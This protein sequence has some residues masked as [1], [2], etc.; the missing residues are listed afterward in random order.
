[1]QFSLSWHWIFGKNLLP[2]QLYSILS[3]RQEI[4]VVEQNCPYQ[5]ADGR[6]F[7]CYHLLGF[8]A[9]DELIT[10]ARIF[11]PKVMT[12]DEKLI[13]I[14]R[15]VVKQ[16]YRGLQLG[17]QLMK[18]AEEYAIREFQF[19]HFALHAQAHLQR[20]YGQVGYQTHGY[21]FDEDGIPH[22]LMKKY[23]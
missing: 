9:D 13:F 6:D 3:L 8:S 5:D 7:D 15:V 1:M 18:K 2:K 21:P 16:E 4:F 10:Y 12:K 20:F 11:P 23:G 19:A 14:G 22:V 17:Y